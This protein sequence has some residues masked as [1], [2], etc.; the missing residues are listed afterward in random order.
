MGISDGLD[1]AVGRWGDAVLACAPLSVRAI[2]HTGR[3]TAQMTAKDAVR[4][5]TDALMEA[6][7]SEDGEEGVRAFVEKRPPVWSGR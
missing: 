1:S 2:K 6:L 5:R 4:Q 3:N 7:A